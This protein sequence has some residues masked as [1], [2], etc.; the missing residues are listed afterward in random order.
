[1]IVY[2]VYIS[3]VNCIIGYTGAFGSVHCIL[4]HCTLYIVHCTMSSG[5]CLLDTRC[6]C[7]YQS[8]PAGKEVGD[9][10]RDIGYLLYDQ[11]VDN[12]SFI[13]V[14]VMNYIYIY[15]RSE[16]VKPSWPMCPGEEVIQRSSAI[17]HYLW[18]VNINYELLITSLHRYLVSL[19]ALPLYPV[20]SNPSYDVIRIDMTQSRLPTLPVA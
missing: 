7:I 6:T 17:K 18:T 3:H 11:I 13:I 1:M 9:I 16:I 12:Y 8:I 15:I 20:A 10:I 19:V 2:T 5:Q 4:W 14:H